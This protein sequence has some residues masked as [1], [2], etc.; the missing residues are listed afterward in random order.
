MKYTE[1]IKEHMIASTMTSNIDFIWRTN[2][3][4]RLLGNGRIS[5]LLIVFGCILM[6]VN[7]SFAQNLRAN[8][9]LQLE[10]RLESQSV[11]LNEPLP[12][13]AL[14]KNNGKEDVLIDPAQIGKSTNFIWVG[15][16]NGR[17]AVAA[18]HAIGDVTGEHP[19]VFVLLRPGQTESRWLELPLDEGFFKAGRKYILQLTYEQFKPQSY[20]GQTVW[21]GSVESN[22]VELWSRQCRKKNKRNEDGG[23]L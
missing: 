12:V 7:A 23:H 4:I 17:T 16:E 6:F 8:T 21:K 18:Y 2:F 11:C 13:Q 14:M 15:N 20:R 19:P 22:E 1:P 3:G 10:L 9:P 5:K